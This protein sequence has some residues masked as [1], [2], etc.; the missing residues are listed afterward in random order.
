MQIRQKRKMYNYACAKFL[1]GKQVM[2]AE[3]MWYKSHVCPP[4][5]TQTN[6]LIRLQKKPLE[7]NDCCMQY[8][9][10]NGNPQRMMPLVHKINFKHIFKVL[11]QCI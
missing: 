8:P 10:R 1:E 3:K 6:L 4:E 2:E 9:Y 5:I 11:F 7:H